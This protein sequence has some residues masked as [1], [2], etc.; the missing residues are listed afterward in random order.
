MSPRLASV[1]PS[2]QMFLAFLRQ[3]RR[4]ESIP[5]LG[6]PRVRLWVQTF[7]AKQSSAMTELLSGRIDIDELG[8]PARSP[9][10]AEPQSR[11][12]GK[13]VD[14]IAKVLRAELQNVSREKQTPLS[15]VPATREE[16][17]LTTESGS[18]LRFD[19]VKRH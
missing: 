19:V 11:R 17:V 2:Y 15:V 13:P 4:R 10:L 14:G 18:P 16:V 3:T 9:A 5:S 7:T 12:S 1:S 8:K 6:A